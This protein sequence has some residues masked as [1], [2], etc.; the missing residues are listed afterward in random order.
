MNTSVRFGGIYVFMCSDRDVFVCSGRSEH[1]C[2]VWRDLLFMCSDSC[3]CVQIVMCLCVQGGVKTSV[4]FGGIYLF[5]C[6]DRDVFVCSGRSENKCEVWRD[7]PVYV[8][9]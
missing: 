7:L 5:M 6:S 9:R 3:L 2:E 1:K 4:R 8:F